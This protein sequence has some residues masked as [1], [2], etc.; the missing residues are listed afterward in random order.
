MTGR[1]RIRLVLAICLL[2]L[3]VLAVLIEIN[4]GTSAGSPPTTLP[5]WVDDHACTEISEVVVP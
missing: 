5:I 1:Q 2:C 3:L 4:A